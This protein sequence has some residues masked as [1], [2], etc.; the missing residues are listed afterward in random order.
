MIAFI[1]LSLLVSPPILWY[2]LYRSVIAQEDINDPNP[3]VVEVNNEFVIRHRWLTKKD[4]QAEVLRDTLK[5]PLT[6]LWIAYA[7][8]AIWAIIIC[9]TY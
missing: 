3:Q 7:L 4:A 1:A 6:K 9:I 2:I 5:H 8:I